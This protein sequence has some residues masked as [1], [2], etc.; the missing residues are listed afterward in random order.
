MR[1]RQFCRIKEEFGKNKNDTIFFD[2]VSKISTA[3]G[4]LVETATIPRRNFQVVQGTAVITEYGNSIPFT[5]KLE[6]LAEFD[7]DNATTKVLRNDEASV[8]DNAVATQFK[9]T[10]AKYVCSG[11]ATYALT[12]N[13]SATATAGSASGHGNLND[14]HIKNVVDQLKKWDVQPVD[15]EGNYICIGSVDALR[16]LR[17][18][19]NF[20]NALRYGKPEYLFTG[21]IGKYNNVRFIEETN[22]LDNSVGGSNYG[23]AVFF[24]DD[25][26]LEAVAIPEEVRYDIPKDF[27][28]DKAIA[29]YALLGYQI[30]WCG[31]GS[32]EGG[33]DTTKGFVPH[34]IHVSSA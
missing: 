23:E 30:I 18:D 11:T 7:V 3:G 15:S 14:Y 27:G 17:D 20:I 22:A 21:E 34:I 31:T 5:G 29:W 10:L 19:S 6:A 24:G 9:A 32:G 8:L 13:G 33:V 4:T 25:S 16:G 26:V 28:R 2:K 1:F 12:T